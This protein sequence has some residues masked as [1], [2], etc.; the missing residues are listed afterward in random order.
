M[1]TEAG[2]PSALMRLRMLHA[3]RAS[4]KGT[5]PDRECSHCG[6]ARARWRYRENLGDDGVKVSP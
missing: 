1:A 6:K 5:Y 3:S 4:T 2:L